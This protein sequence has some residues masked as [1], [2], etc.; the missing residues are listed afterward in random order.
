MNPTKLKRNLVSAAVVGALALSAAVSA[1]DAY[2]YAPIDY[3]GADRSQVFGVNERGDAIGNAFAD[4]PGGT[5]DRFPFVYDIRKDRFTLVD[6]VAGFDATSVLANNN[7]GDIVGSVFDEAIPRESGVLIDKKGR[8]EVF[9]HPDAVSVTQPRAIN[10][11]GVVTGFRDNNDPFDFQVGW[12]YD[13]KR[14]TFTDIVPSAATIAQGIN[15]RGDVVGS[16]TFFT[17]DDPCNPGAPPGGSVGYGWLRTTD[18]NVSFFTVNGERTRARGITDSGTI[19]GWTL[20]E[21]T[22]E[23]RGFVTDAE[24]GYCEDIAVGP[25]G[26]LAYPGAQATFAQAITNWGAVVGSYNDA[27]GEVQSFVAVPK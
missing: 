22:G 27:T 20:N 19:V 15:G 25:D 9:D 12:I 5:I 11:R 1:Q 16:A 14:G 6:D 18:G 2:D 13:P 10:N 23:V 24:I 26:I 4:G 8:A 21:T 17:Q 7:R 3:P